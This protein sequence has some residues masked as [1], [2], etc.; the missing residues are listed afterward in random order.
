MPKKFFSHPLVGPLLI[1]ILGTLAYAN[2]FGVPFVLDD[3]ESITNNEVIRQLGNFAPGGSGY[4]FSPRRWFGYLSFAVNYHFGGLEVAGYHLFNLAIHLLTGLLV[5]ALALLTFRTPQLKNSALAPQAGTAA[6]LAGLLF[7][8]HPVQTQAV[9]YLVQRLTSLCTLLYLLAIVLYAWG[10]L[11]ADQRLQQAGT[12]KSLAGESRWQASLL[13]LGSV[14]AAVLAMKTKEIAFTLP[15]AA[16]LY[17][18]C[19]F[20]GEP[21]RRLLMLL[22]LLCTLPIIPLLVFGTGDG[23][24]GEDLT[25][26]SGGRVQSDLPRLHYLFTQFRVIVTYLRLLVLPVNQNLDYDYPVFSSF[27]A[28]PVLLSFL[29]LTALLLLALYL[30]GFKNEESGKGGESRLA[31][32]GI[33]WF[34]LA[35]SIESSIIPII[36]V[37]FEHRLY[38]PSVGLAL[39]AGVLVLQAGR[40]SSAYF[41]GNIPITVATVFILA[42]TLATWQRNQVWQDPVTLWADVVSKSPDKVRALYNYGCYLPDAGRAEEAVQVLT[43]VVTLDPKHGDGWHNLGKSYLVLNRVG[44]AL[45]ALKEAV[46]L[47]PKLE[48]AKLNLATALL[49]SSQYRDAVIILEQERDRSPSRGDIRFNL[50]LG[51]LGL[52][53]INAAKGEFTA[54]QGLDPNLARQFAAQ[55]NTS[56]AAR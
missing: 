30:Y 44:D 24:S 16:L 17:E 34:F 12:G 2:S 54:L 22:P 20:R 19:F 28:V 29:L 15:I 38:L 14:V 8:V 3:A 1:L 48:N 32:F 26:G 13:L 49:M 42:L 46:R 37:I 6:A 33:F 11:I 53:N 21:K 25:A 43:R 35:L 23:I 47:N 4:D 18:I 40:K 51:Y 27:F 45:P 52:G 56:A 41:Q 50:G 10:R 5:Y 31:A 7:V 36:D 39:S 9:T 55:M